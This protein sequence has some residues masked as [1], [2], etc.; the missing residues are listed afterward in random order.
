MAFD[1]FGHNDDQLEANFGFGLANVQVYAMDGDPGTYSPAYLGY[2]GASGGIIYSEWDA[3]TELLSNFNRG[4]DNTGVAPPDNNT[5]TQLFLG[6][7]G[8]STNNL[9]RSF[10]GD[11]YEVIV[12]DNIINDAQTIIVHNYL[13]AKYNQ[14]LGNDDLYDEDDAANGNYDHDVAGIGRVDISNRHEDSQG[15]GIVRVNNPTNL[16]DDEF[17]I[18]GHDNDVLDFTNITDIPTGVLNRL[19]RVWRTSE[20]STAG[21]GVDVGSINISFDLTGLTFDPTKLVLLVDA[22]NDGLFNDETPITGVINL[23]SNIYEWSALA[24]ISN[25]L[26]FTLAITILV[27][28]PIELTNFDTNCEGDKVNLGWS[29]ETEINNDYFTVE[30]SRDGINFEAIATINGAGNSIAT[31]NYNWTDD[32]PLSGTSYYRLKQTDFDGAKEI[33]LTRSVNCGEQ[34]ILI[35]PNP[36]ENEF[37]LK[38][39]YGGTITLVDHAGRLILEQVVIAGES[40]IQSDQIATGSY[41]AIITLENGKREVHKLVKR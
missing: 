23:G 13:A 24:A 27:P 35:Y 28:L 7:H 41:M 36:F 15:T 8:T 12:Y 17:F 39:K 19:E 5:P 16:N 34:G 31:I 9:N 25:N 2:T 30:R 10:A 1:G 26:R 14:S 4:A 33:F 38:S 21:A 18:W 22:D 29:T 20:A 37:I 40:T 11:M 3:G 32:N 6:R